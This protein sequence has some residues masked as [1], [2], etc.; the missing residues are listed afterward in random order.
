[1]ILSRA[2]DLVAMVPER[3]RQL[4]AVGVLREVLALPSGQ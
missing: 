3:G 4:P 1:L 2:R